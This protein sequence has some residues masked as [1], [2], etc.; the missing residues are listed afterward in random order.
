[1][2]QLND[3]VL[4]RN[5]PEITGNT[6]ICTLNILRKLQIFKPFSK[7][8]RKISVN[9]NSSLRSSEMGHAL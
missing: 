7:R 9:W 1:M 3:L 4:K 5:S 8:T 6:K 2:Y